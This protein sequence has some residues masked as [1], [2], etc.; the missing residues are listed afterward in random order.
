MLQEKTLKNQKNSPYVL[1]GHKD[2][3]SKPPNQNNKN[4]FS[5]FRW[6]E[7]VEG[8]RPMHKTVA[9]SFKQLGR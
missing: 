4:D 1:L 8:S 2:L 5:I 9:C 3:I 7:E 6:L